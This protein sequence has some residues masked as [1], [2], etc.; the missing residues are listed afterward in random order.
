MITDDEFGVL[1][2][3]CRTQARIFERNIASARR[4]VVGGRKAPAEGERLVAFITDQQER[5]ARARAWMRAAKKEGRH[6]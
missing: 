6:V 1:E 4:Q 3:A 5:L 2:L